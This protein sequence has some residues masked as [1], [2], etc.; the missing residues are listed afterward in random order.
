M[1]HH[2]EPDRPD[3]RDRAAA[4]AIPGDVAIEAEA[5]PGAEPAG[6]P[7]GGATDASV[8]E[9]VCRRCSTVARTTGDFCP[10]CGGS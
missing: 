3:N 5:Q 9:R 1:G 10:H 7:V 6:C 8:P 2:Q 4:R